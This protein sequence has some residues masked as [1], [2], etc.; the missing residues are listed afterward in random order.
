VYILDRFVLVQGSK[1]SPDSSQVLWQVGYEGEMHA[2]LDAAVIIHL[3]LLWLVSNDKHCTG[4]YQS[5]IAFL[6]E[7]PRE[8]E[9]RKGGVYFF[10]M[11]LVQTRAILLPPPVAVCF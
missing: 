7:R 1:L 9:S 6:W 8:K 4:V 3:N 10:C 5:I 11:R 2:T